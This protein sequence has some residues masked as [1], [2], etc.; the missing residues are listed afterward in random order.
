MHIAIQGALTGAGIAVVLFLIDYLLSRSIVAD[1]TALRRDAT[2]ARNE[3]K[4]MASLM[5]YC[6]LLP[7]VFAFAFWMVWG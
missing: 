6:L 5:R 7:P 4:R 1:K 2:M 3:K